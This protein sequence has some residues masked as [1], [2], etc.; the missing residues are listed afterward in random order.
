[1][2]PDLF[3]NPLLSA[4]SDE[5]RTQMGRR[6]MLEILESTGDRRPGGMIILDDMLAT[7]AIAAVQEAGLTVGRDFMIATHANRGSSTLDLYKPRIIRIE[8]DPDEMVEAMFGMLER[9]MSGVE[10][11]PAAFT[12]ASRVKVGAMVGQV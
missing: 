9:M 8:V 2:H 10:K 6:V 4:H 1:M 7:G 11:T 5:T 3:I 12:V